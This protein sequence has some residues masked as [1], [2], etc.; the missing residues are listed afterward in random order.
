MEICPFYDPKN[1]GKPYESLN[2]PP[3]CP[4][5]SSFKMDPIERGQQVIK[6]VEWIELCKRRKWQEDEQRWWQNAC[7][8]G[9]AEHVKKAF[10]NKI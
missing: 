3:N 8:L 7:I 5:G 9:I 4:L 10:S 6:H 2:F 1:Q